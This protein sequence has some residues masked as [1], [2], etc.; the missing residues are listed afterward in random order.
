MATKLLKVIQRESGPFNP[1][2]N[3]LS[4]DFEPE[5]CTDL[6]KSYLDFQIDFGQNGQPIPEKTILLG[7]PLVACQYST[8][9]LIKHA[10][11]RSDVGLVEQQRFNNVYAETMKQFLQSSE[12][13]KSSVA[14]G[15][16]EI[17]TDV[18][19]TAHIIVPIDKILGC[20]SSEQLYPD[21]RMGKTRLELELEDRVNPFYTRHNEN[22]GEFNMNCNDV[23]PVDDAFNSVTLTQKFASLQAAL[24]YYVIGREYTLTYTDMEE[25]DVNVEIAAV[26][27]ANGVVSLVFAE[28]I[29]VEAAELTNISI[30]TINEPDNGVFLCTQQQNATAAAVT[31]KVFTCVDAN[32][33][34]FTIGDN[35]SIGYLTSLIA[36]PGPA[37]VWSVVTAKIVDTKPNTTTPTN[38]DITISVAVSIPV[39]SRLSQIF[40]FASLEQALVTWSVSECNLIQAKM[41]LK[42]EVKEFVFKTNLLENVNYPD[43]AEF[44]RQVDLDAGCDLVT[45]ININNSSDPLLG[46]AVFD[47]Y[48][49]SVNSVDTIT[50]DVVIDFASNGSL[51][52]DRL[53]TCLDDIKRLNLLNGEHV[54][55]CIPERIE[56][57][58]ALV[59][60][61]VVEFKFRTQSGDTAGDSGMLYFYK[62]MTKVF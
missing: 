40:T 60:N 19:G 32:V 26:N 45:A 29:E 3:I 8:A 50:K 11:L 58:Q 59:P 2:N 53:I 39:Q 21:Y 36:G 31:T 37:D 18:N 57:E 6:S 43:V 1:S 47:T 14:F 5:T 38:I 35:I 55:V 10:T 28:Q 16:V 15:N 62:R 7:N 42:E 34:D 13:F 20:A 48:R 30:E 22:I 27:Y 49:N 23:T 25:I 56:P 24:T 51:Y 52:F 4:I 33:D 61:N 54:T 44:R 17:K 9:S 41:V 12:A 46:C